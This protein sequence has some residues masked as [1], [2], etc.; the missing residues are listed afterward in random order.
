MPIHPPYPPWADIETIVGVAVTQ[1]IMLV[2]V[3]ARIASRHRAPRCSVDARVC[4]RQRGRI[5]AG[6]PTLLS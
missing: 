1:L 6:S 4:A 5:V 2:P 3:V